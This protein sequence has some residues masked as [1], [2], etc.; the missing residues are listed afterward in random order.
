M[1]RFVVEMP[2][3][4]ADLA[5]RTL[6]QMLDAGDKVKSEEGYWH[7]RIKEFERVRS[8]VN[9]YENDPTTVSQLQ[10]AIRDAFTDI[11]GFAP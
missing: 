4:D 10:I 1:I 6:L 2:G 9:Q 8:A 7:V 5:R 11:L 3:N